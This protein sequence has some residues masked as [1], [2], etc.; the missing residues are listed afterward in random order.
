MKTK[1]IVYALG[2]AL[3]STSCN[4]FLD[5]DPKGQLTPSTFFS[6]Q[7]ELDMATYALYNKICMTKPIPI[8]PFPVG[9]VTI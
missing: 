8:L 3:L 5:E 2:L 9:R 6:T 7:E 4:D 1:Y